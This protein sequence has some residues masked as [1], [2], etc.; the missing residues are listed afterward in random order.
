MNN[1]LLAQE[2][3]VHVNFTAGENLTLVVVLVVSLIALLVAYLL[4]RQVLAA[5]QGGEKMR[6]VARAIQEGSRAYLTRQFRTL[7]IFVALLFFLLLV[8]K[9]DSTSV[10]I[11][12]SIAFLFGAGFS[13]LAGFT[14]MNLTVRGNVRVAAAANFGGLR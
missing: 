14:G 10:R 6:E 9:A 12:R 3:T 13:G 1:G 11:G 7:V 8:L 2:S 4:V 5:D